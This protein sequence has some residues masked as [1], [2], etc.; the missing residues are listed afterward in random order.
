[1]A[2]TQ[3]SSSLWTRKPAL[4]HSP[5]SPFPRL[6]QRLL[7][8][9]TPAKR[10]EAD[11]TLNCPASG[12]GSR[13]P[14]GASF[15]AVGSS[16]PGPSAQ[17]P[18]PLGT[19]RAFLFFSLAYVSEGKEYWPD[20]PFRAA[21]PASRLKRRPTPYARISREHAAAATPLPA[22]AYRHLACGARLQIPGLSAA[23][24]AASPS[25]RS[26]SCTNDIYLMSYSFMA[27]T[28]DILFHL[29]PRRLLLA[30]FFPTDLILYTMPPKRRPQRKSVARPFRLMA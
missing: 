4:L 21:F 16:C 14:R 28:M 27:C 26:P 18:L 17:R 29:V 3:E 19:P 25:K 9:P 12:S 10:Y 13:S 15:A 11:A 1:V 7:S 6:D 24:F 22:A 2:A 20:R 8:N 5:R 23:D 30:L